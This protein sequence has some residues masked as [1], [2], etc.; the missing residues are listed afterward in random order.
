M[1][2]KAVVSI[3]QANNTAEGYANRSRRDFQFGLGN[4][5]LLSSQYFIPEAFR[6]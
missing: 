5:V 4:G 2:T 3:E 1:V 6:D